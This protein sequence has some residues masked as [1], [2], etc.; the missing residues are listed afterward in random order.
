MSDWVNI[1][2]GESMASVRAKL[3][4]LG[5]AIA[6]GG[7]ARYHTTTTSVST[8]I[9]TWTQLTNNKLGALTS[10]EHLPSGVTTLIDPTTGKVDL[11]E[12][13][14]GDLVTVQVE[15][16]LTIASNNTYAELRLQT[17]ENGSTVDNV[18]QLG[19]LNRGTGLYTFSVH[20]M[21]DVSGF[22]LA[23]LVPVEVRCSKD[24]TLQPRSLLISVD[25]SHG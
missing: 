9:D 6:G 10:E 7:H 21:I 24:S 5:T 17:A 2:D 23:A 13:L 19:D 22:N 15:F 20:H 14:A 12:L 25:R 1:Q 3:N 8:G 16:Q 11:S 18:I 4:L